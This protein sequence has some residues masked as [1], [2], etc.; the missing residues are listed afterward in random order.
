MCPGPEGRSLKENGIGTEAIEGHSCDRLSG[1]RG[2]SFV[3]TLFS[4]NYSYLERNQPLP[5]MA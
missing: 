4:N 2:K 5:T 1:R 3:L